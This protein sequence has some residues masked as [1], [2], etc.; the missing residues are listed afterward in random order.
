MRISDWSSDVCSSD[1][2]CRFAGHVVADESRGQFE[3]VDF[4]RHAIL[5]DQNDVAPVVALVDRQDHQGV[6]TACARNIFLCDR[7]SQ[8]PNS[9]HLYDL[10]MPTSAK[11][12]KKRL[13]TSPVRTTNTEENH[14]ANQS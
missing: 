10:R 9:N 4:Q 13:R 14:S 12:N 2:L 3:A 5:F 6:D 7:K 11:K 1:L 8:R